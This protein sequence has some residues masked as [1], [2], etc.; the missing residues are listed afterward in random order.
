[1]DNSSSIYDP[2]A[3]AST[4]LGWDADAQAKLVVGVDPPKGKFRQLAGWVLLFV[5]MTS[6]MAVLLFGGKSSAIPGLLLCF[7][8]YVCVAAN[9]AISDKV[10]TGSKPQLFV[11]FCRTAF[12]WLSALAVWLFAALWVQ[13]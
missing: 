3:E 1:M 8:S 11:R 5:L 2:L 4:D 9:G 10:S 13:V 7:V 6:G 12:F